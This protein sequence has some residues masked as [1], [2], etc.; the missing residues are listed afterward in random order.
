MYKNFVV[1]VKVASLTIKRCWKPCLGCLSSMWSPLAVLQAK[2]VMS[3]GVHWFRGLYARAEWGQTEIM[4]AQIKTMAGRHC[5]VNVWETLHST[6]T[7]SVVDRKTGFPF[8]TLNTVRSMSLHFVCLIILKHQD[9]LRVTAVFRVHSFIKA[10]SLYKQKVTCK[11]KVT[12]NIT[13]W[14]LS[15]WLD[16]VIAIY[17]K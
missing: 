17:R 10:L 6:E 8:H 12:V 13:T 4:A 11:N 16:L 5:L 7:D 3:S 15:R 1:V 14:K 2:H 9:L